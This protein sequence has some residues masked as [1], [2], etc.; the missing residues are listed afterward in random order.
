M[1]RK[2]IMMQWVP[3]LSSRIQFL[4]YLDWQRLGIDSFSID[5]AQ[6]LMRPGLNNIQKLNDL[7]ALFPVKKGLVHVGLRSLLKPTITDNGATFRSGLDG[8]ELELNY[9]QVL[10]LL[11]QYQLTPVIND[12]QTAKS[13]LGKTDLKGFIPYTLAQQATK[14][15]KGFYLAYED[16]N[17]FN[18]LITEIKSLKGQFPDK[19]LYLEGAFTPTQWCQVQQVGIDYMAS[20]SPFMD[21]QKGIVYEKQAMLDLKS[22]IYQFDLKTISD[23]CGCLCCGQF[24]RSYLHHLIE[25]TPLLAQYYLSLHNAYQLT[26]FQN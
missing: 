7:N 16:W 1:N 18:D 15:I 20:Q 11:T 6:C 12:I 5:W 4:N 19:A 24:S 26:V 13:M 21:A 17:D 14:H 9:S 2:K 25:H 3:S 23:N 8:G 22:P 10:T